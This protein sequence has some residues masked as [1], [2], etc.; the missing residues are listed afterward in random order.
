MCSVVRRATLQ[1]AVARKGRV[2]R[3]RLQ[4]TVAA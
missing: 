4:G 3:A 1:R 2:S